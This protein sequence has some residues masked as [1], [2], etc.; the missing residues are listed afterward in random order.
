MKPTLNSNYLILTV[1]NFCM[2][3]YCFF[4]IAKV[5]ERYILIFPQNQAVLS[6]VFVL[7]CNPW[8]KKIILNS[9]YESFYL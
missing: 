4:Y 5:N 6:K 7:F 9:C 8:E 3:T 1:N 2:L